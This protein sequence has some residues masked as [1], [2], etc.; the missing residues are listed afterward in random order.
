MGT[1]GDVITIEDVRE[2]SSALICHTAKWTSA[3]PMQ[4][5]LRLQSTSGASQKRPRNITPEYRLRYSGGCH[6]WSDYPT[7]MG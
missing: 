3:G 6:C 4:T 2:K 5:P 7:G 1:K